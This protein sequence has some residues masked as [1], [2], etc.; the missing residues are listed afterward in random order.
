MR[1]RLE[2]FGLVLLALI[3]ATAVVFPFTVPDINIDTARAYSV[4]PGTGSGNGASATTPVAGGTIGSS[5]GNLAAPFEN[6]FRSINNVGSVNVPTTPTQTN[7]S[8]PHGSDWIT[9]WFKNEFDQ[10][11]NW[12]YGVAGFHISGFFLA[13]LGI[14]SWILGLVKSGVDWVLGALN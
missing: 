6:F 11:D 12:L 14:F 7:L 2:T 9:A 13:I 4:L 5:L 3:G 1:R 8:A 10:F